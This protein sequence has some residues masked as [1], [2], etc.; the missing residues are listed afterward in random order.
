MEDLDNRIR[1]LSDLDRVPLIRELIRIDAQAQ[2]LARTGRRARL[3]STTRN[4]AEGAQRQSER[5]GM[6]IYFLRYRSPASGA[7]A[8]DMELCH[9]LAEKLQA[10]GQWTGEAEIS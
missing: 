9:I 5:L 10:K 2:E 4:R 7:R 6:I 8:K 1:R 3:G